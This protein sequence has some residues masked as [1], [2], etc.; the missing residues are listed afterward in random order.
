MTDA[1]FANYPFEYWHF[2]YGDRLYVVNA[3]AAGHPTPRA[4][5]Y[6]YVD[7]SRVGP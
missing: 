4:A 6:P 1:G 7:A 5:F 2:D 3:A